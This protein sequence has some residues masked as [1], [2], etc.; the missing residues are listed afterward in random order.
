ME[1]ADQNE[2]A[3]RK[4][5]IEKL[6]KERGDTDDYQGPYAYGVYGIDYI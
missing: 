3:E 5:E 6:N 2:R 4:I 1:Q